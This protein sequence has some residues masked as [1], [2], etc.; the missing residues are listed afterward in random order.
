MSKEERGKKE[1]ER[2]EKKRK[3][4]RKEN[5]TLTL[6]SSS[7]PLRLVRRSWIISGQYEAN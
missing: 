6:R 2:K 7:S 5:N 1:I 4:K 3:R